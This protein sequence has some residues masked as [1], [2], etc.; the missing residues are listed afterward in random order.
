MHLPEVEFM[1]L[2]MTT[3]SNNEHALPS[4]IRTLPQAEL[5]HRELTRYMVRRGEACPV[6]TGCDDA[7]R[8]LRGPHEHAHVLPLDLN[9][10]DHIDHIL[11]WTS[12]GLDAEAQQVVRG[13]RQTYTKGAIEPLRLALV[14]SGRLEDLLALPAEYGKTVK[15]ILGDRAGAREWRSLTPFIAPRYLKRSGKNALVG[16]IASELSSRGLSQ[17]TDVRVFNPGS[18]AEFLQYRHF[19]RKRRKGVQ[20]PADFGYSIQLR[21]NSPVKGPLC[22]GYASHFG[23]GL[24]R[25]IA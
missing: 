17:P 21:F 9:R 6:L 20:P 25:A 15:E 10:D 13:I 11:I 4:V 3:Q 18:S 2:S 1:L 7:K 24:F 23:M 8:P 5:I 19:V 14:G 16:Q 12:R 22:L